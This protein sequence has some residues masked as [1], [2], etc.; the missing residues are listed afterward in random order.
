MIDRVLKS[1]PFAIVM[2]ALVLLYVFLLLAA[3]EMHPSSKTAF[4]IFG[5]LI[6][7]DAFERISRA[8]KRG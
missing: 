1:K 8:W 3:R 2:L 4:L 7:V 6:M 5:L